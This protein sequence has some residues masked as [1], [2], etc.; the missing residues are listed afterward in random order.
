MDGVYSQFLP[1]K[2]VDRMILAALGCPRPAVAAAGPVHVAHAMLD[3][4]GD[5]MDDGSFDRS[6]AGS[7]YIL[8][9]AEVEAEEGEESADRYAETRW[10]L[11][12]NITALLRACGDL[13]ADRSDLNERAEFLLRCGDLP[14]WE[15]AVRN[16]LAAAWVGDAD[17]VTDCVTAYVTMLTQKERDAAM[18]SLVRGEPALEHTARASAAVTVLAALEQAASIVK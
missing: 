11:V 5:S 16:C 18:L 14:A 8:T 4:L 6:A 2:V 1:E 10:Y 3:A 15:T 12:H 9:T 17:A 7:D 13:L